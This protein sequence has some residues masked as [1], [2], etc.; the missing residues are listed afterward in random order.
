MFWIPLQGK[1][2][3]DYVDYYVL[4]LYYDYYVFNFLTFLFA[5]NFSGETVHWLPSIDIKLMRKKRVPLDAR[6]SWLSSVPTKDRNHQVGWHDIIYRSIIMYSILWIGF[7][8]YP[9][10]QWEAIHR[11]PSIDIKLMRKNVY[12]SMR[13]RDRPIHHRSPPGSVSHLQNYHQVGW[14]NIK[15]RVRWLLCIQFCDCPKLQ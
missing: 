7:P 10:L 9:R 6:S 8:V 4:L 15:C 5:L 3:L 13:T 12:L 2:I 1:R 11:L 14:H